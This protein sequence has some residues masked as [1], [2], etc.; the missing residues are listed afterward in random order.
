MEFEGNL[1][2]GLDDALNITRLFMNVMWG[3]II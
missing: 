2:R 1:H 3:R